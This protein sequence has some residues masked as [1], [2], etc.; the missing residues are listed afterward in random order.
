MLENRGV[1]SGTRG[2]GVYGEGVKFVKEEGTL[3]TWSVCPS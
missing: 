1:S 2:F 3:L